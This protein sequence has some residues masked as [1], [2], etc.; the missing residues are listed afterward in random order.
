LPSGKELAFLKPSPGINYVALEPRSPDAPGEEKKEGT[1]LT[2]SGDGLFRWPI[3]AEPQT[4]VIGIGP[5]QRLPVQG[6]GDG[7]IAQSRDGRVLAAAQ[8]QGAVV[9]H[10]DQPDQPIKLGPQDDVRFIAVSPD[11]QWV[12]TGSFGTPGGAK[13]WQL[14]PP[15]TRSKTAKLVKDLPGGTFCRP[16]FSPDSKRLIL[17][18]YD[19]ATATRVIRCWEVETWVERSFTAPLEGLNP[20]FSPD[21][22]LLV[23]ETGSGVARLLDADT[24][25][26]YARLEDSDQHR[27]NHYAFTPDGTKL[28]CATG[29]GHCVHVWDLQAIRRQLVEMELNWESPPE[30][31]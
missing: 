4:G 5:A 27:T 10:A 19:E 12:A 1:L 8:F 15:G 28:A 20:A 25:R 21:G 23:V 29:D 18:G 3:R 30:T 14:G 7:Q 16:V 17:G 24:G 9:V 13:V 2:M 26:E 11:G 31:K 22:K 6:I